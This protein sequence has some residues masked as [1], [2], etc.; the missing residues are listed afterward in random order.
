K[1]ALGGLLT[2]I[3]TWIA[4]QA[5]PG[6]KDGIAGKL[7]DMGTK[8]GQAIVDGILAAIKSGWHNL[9]D[10]LSKNPLS[11]LS[12]LVGGNKAP[13]G[14]PAATTAGAPTAGAPAGGIAAAGPAIIAMAEATA[15]VYGWCE[16]FVGDVMA[17]MGLKYARASSAEAHAH[18]QPLSPGLGPEGAI[19]FYPW[20]NEGHVA[21]SMGDG[22]HIFGTMDNA[23]GTGEGD[24]YWTT[25]YG[26]TVNP[27]AAGGL[28]KAGQPILA[29]IGEGS[30]DEAVLPLDPANPIPVALATSSSGVDA[31][32][33]AFGRALTS[34]PANGSSIFSGK[35]WDG[36]AADLQRFDGIL[37]AIQPASGGGGG[38]GG[39]GAAAAP[40][41][42]AAFS[43]PGMS[44]A[45]V[46]KQ[47]DLVAYY[48]DSQNQGANALAAAPLAA[49]G[50]VDR[51]TLALL[52]EGG[53][54]EIV[55]PE[56]TMRR[57]IREEMA[58]LGQG[59]QVH[60]H[61]NMSVQQAPGATDQLLDA[62]LARLA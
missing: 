47:Q 21:F 45:D 60:L 28:V 23:Q 37:S 11:V 39:G 49:G 4:S 62:L 7:L 48:A 41:A 1:T 2:N 57:I 10:W 59:L 31:L 8:G 30:T 24:G 16:Q 44:P 17:R 46:K 14:G 50:V 33:T 42:A 35:L 3:G 18:M 32:S 54:R 53:Q 12:N 27:M 51:P 34:I 25:P 52:G 29:M 22:K 15:G 55:S 5:D 13:G 9:T 38:G 58:G 61:G 19:V 40:A 36:L 56:T 20:Q 26:W 43:G 6:N